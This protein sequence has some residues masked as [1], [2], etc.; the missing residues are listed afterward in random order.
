MPFR[1]DFKQ[2]VVGVSE[3]DLSYNFAS[4]FK[5]PKQQLTLSL[6]VLVFPF[7][8]ISVG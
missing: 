7:F 3:V 2:G 4:C 8:L 6:I 5:T 1:K